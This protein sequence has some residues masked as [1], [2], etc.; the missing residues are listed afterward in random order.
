MLNVNFSEIFFK[1]FKKIFYNFYLGSNCT[2]P[3]SNSCTECY[4]NFFLGKENECLTKPEEEIKIVSTEFR[5]DKMITKV[6]FSEKINPD[7]NYDKIIPTLYTSKAEEAKNYEITKFELKSGSVLEMTLK[8][9]QNMEKGYM[10]VKFLEIKNIRKFDN[11]KIF[12][13][14][15]ET[16]IS[17]IS[18]YISA[19]EA[20]VKTAADS[21][22][23]SLK[24]FLGAS[25]IFSIP[26]AFVLLKIFQMI[27][28]M[29]L[30]NV[31]HP[32]N[33]SFFLSILSQSAIDDLPNVFKFLSDDSCRIK[34][35]R[36][37]DE[38]ISCQVFSDLGN[39]FFLISILIG[40][41]FLFKITACIF[42]KG[43]M[44]KYPKKWDSKMNL[45]FW[46]D[47]IESIQLDI[48]INSFLAFESIESNTLIA[49]INF[50][51]SCIFVI[52]GIFTA[53]MLFHF[54]S[55][56]AKIYV[57]PMDCDNDYKRMYKK[58][59]FLFEEFNVENFYG[60]N[61]R[62]M[63]MIKDPLIALFMVKSHDSPFFQILM[64]LVVLITFTFL[65]FSYSPYKK[66]ILNQMEI[67]KGV[68]YIL[69]CS[70]F[71]ILSLIQENWDKKA[72]FN[73]IGYPVI[74]VISI[75]ILGNIGYGIYDIGKNIKEIFKKKKKKEEEEKKPDLEDSVNLE[76]QG[77]NRRQENMRK[78]KKNGI[79][80]KKTRKN[81][82]DKTNKKSHKE[83]GLEGRRKKKS[84]RKRREIEFDDLKN[85]K[86]EK[87]IDLVMKKGNKKKARRRKKEINSK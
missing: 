31:K 29:V 8:I 68:I 67:F 20:Q 41:K 42:K 44:N 25:F 58:Y 10:M 84:N 75:L 78:K 50:A 56:A 53:F 34:K 47:L 22:Q 82:M 71:L 49:G 13:T 23:T 48:Y 12:L 38:E 66:Q 76:L 2:S 57:Y 17:P 51:F 70:G 69:A 81:G 14:E 73:Y 33:L 60:R 35:S 16:K 80:K 40:L 39:Y 65:D 46:L 27:D 52:A 6:T 59:D 63:C 83:R 26:M 55:K 18:F 72:Q 3:E 86:G 79:M 24:I 30:F 37:I 5:D 4:E 19:T 15:E 85:F 64:V 28:F 45:V 21:T 43:K 11:D 74:G 7:I 62:A 1:F 87:E 61:Y 9:D 36:F 32:R 77:F 54:V